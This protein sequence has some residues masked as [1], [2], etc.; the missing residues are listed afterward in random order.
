MSYPDTDRV[1]GRT[2]QPV[3][4]QVR[5][6]PAPPSVRK[7]ATKSVAMTYSLNPA[8]PNASAIQ[9]AAFE[10]TRTRVLIQAWT[11]S[12]AVLF[13]KPKVSPDA[14]TTLIPCQ[15]AFMPANDGRNPWEFLGCDPIWI[16]S[17]GTLTLVTVVKEYE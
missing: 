10:P 2:P 7:R 16:N 17:L 9:V 14:A 11:A 13:E 6:W 15:G 3:E 12:I 8:D 1:P 4:V 5:N